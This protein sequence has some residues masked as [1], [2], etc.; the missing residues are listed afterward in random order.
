MIFNKPKSKD[1]SS[2]SKRD[3]VAKILSV[4]AAL[5]LWF[6]VVDVQNVVEEKTIYNVPVDVEQLELSTG[7]TVV[8]GMN[9]SIDVVV[10]GSKSDLK[11]LTNKDISAKVAKGDYDSFGDN[12]CDIKINTPENVSV[13]SRSVQNINV[14]VDNLHEKEFDVKAV[15]LQYKLAP[16][17]VIDSVVPKVSKV[18]VSG[19]E[20]LI[21][22]VEGAEIRIIRNDII[23]NNISDSSEKIVLVDES[24]NVINDSY[25]IISPEYTGYEI[26]ISETK[27][28]EDV[29][30]AFSNMDEISED[31]FVEFADKSVIDFVRVICK[32]DISD[33]VKKSDISAFAD[34]SKID[35]EGEFSLPVEFQ[36]REGVTLADGSEFSVDVIS[37]KLSSKT[38]LLEVMNTDMTDPEFNYKLSENFV[39]LKGPQAVLDNISS[40]Y[41]LVDPS[42]ISAGAKIEAEVKLFDD[43]GK[44]IIDNRISGLSPVVVNVISVYDAAT[45]EY[46]ED[47]AVRLMDFVDQSLDYFTN[48]DMS[49]EYDL[50]VS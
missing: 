17:H 45:T 21:N 19:P 25:L 12:W 47:A 36:L 34:V 29:A 13:V 11:N 31:Y 49:F 27:S 30:V 5:A 1:S 35:F 28:F 41:V 9:Y 6:Y 33:S 42:A 20:S 48:N 37:Y 15:A 16:N 40:A 7:L 26:Q 10:R 23:D 32:K 8:S 24:G 44:E 43:D 18:V 14:S 39:F 50:L 38:L 46:V 2:K 3:I 4:I 22:K